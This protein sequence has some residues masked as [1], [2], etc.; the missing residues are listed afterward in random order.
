MALRR[1]GPA[2][3]ASGATVI[4]GML[5]LLVAESADISGLGP[6]A[7]IGIAVAPARHDHAAARAAGDLR[8]V[9]LL[10]AP[11]EVRLRPS[12][13]PAASGPGRAARSPGGPAR[14]GWSRRCCSACCTLGLIGFKIGSLTDGAVVPR[15]P[16]VGGG[17]AGAR[18]ALPGRRGRAGRRD[19]Q[20]QPRPRRCAPPWPAPR[21]SPRCPPPVTDGDLV[22]LQGTLASQPDSQAAFTTVD[23]VRAAVHQIPGADAKVG[24]GTAVTMDVENYAA[25]DRNVIIP[26][27]LLVVHDHPRPA[28]AG[29][30]RAAGADRHRDPVLR[31]GARPVRARVPAPVR[32]RRRGHLGAAV[33]LRVPGR[34]RHR[35]QH[36]PDDP[37]PRGNH[38]VRYPARRA[39][40][41]W[42]RPAA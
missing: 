5:C 21:A 9:G 33:H 15:H 37:G 14:C 6:V 29:G 38:P 24:G 2:I 4:A 3:I 8:A 11:A 36:L 31:G 41:G 23:R 16:G 27:V 35:L 19:R 28:A 25:R 39:S 17:R 10:A 1:A 7:A 20:R 13:R 26:L 30:G 34:A 42:P 12:R 32:V 22:Y 18:A 40:P